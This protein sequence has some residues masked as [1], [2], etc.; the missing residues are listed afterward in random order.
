MLFSISSFNAAVKIA[1]THK[2]RV[3]AR[4]I[5]RRVR[6][7]HLPAAGRTTTS[8][9][10]AGWVRERESELT[11]FVYDLLIESLDVRRRVFHLVKKAILQF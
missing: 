4:V 6:A 1:Q 5:M 2:E 7:E 9:A 3:G 11:D 10:A 8:P